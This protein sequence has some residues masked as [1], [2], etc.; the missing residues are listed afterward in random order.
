MKVAEEYSVEEAYKE[1]CNYFELEPQVFGKNKLIKILNK[2]ARVKVVREK[3]IVEKKVSK[4]TPS[5]TIDLVGELQR[6][7]LLYNVRM[8]T[9]FSNRRKGEGV[10]ARVHFCRYLKTIQPEISSMELGRFFK[11]HHS[12]ILHYWYDS[13]C[14]CKIPPLPKPDAPMLSLPSTT[15]LI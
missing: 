4:A 12:T 3:V 6:I 5:I 8:K 15:A 9:V 2:V 11:R 10:Q 7:C 13:K 1:I 14:V